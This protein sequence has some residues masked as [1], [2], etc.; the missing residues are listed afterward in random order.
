MQ[1]NL[2]LLFIIFPSLSNG[3]MIDF[4]IEGETKRERIILDI[5]RVSL[6]IPT[7]LFD[8]G[9]QNMLV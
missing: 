4:L 7:T 5:S 2:I 3:N 8:L 9:Y 6:L 1:G